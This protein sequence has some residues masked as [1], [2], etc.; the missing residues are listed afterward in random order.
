MEQML[1]NLSSR[2]RE[3]SEVMTLIKR[4]YRG[5]VPITLYI[6]MD[7]SVLR[8]RHFKDIMTPYDVVVPRTNYF[9]SPQVVKKKHRNPDLKKLRTSPSLVK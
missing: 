8:L 9:I 6:P 7:H 1:L 4:I 3:Y 5:K 2:H